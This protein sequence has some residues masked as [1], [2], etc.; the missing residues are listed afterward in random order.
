MESLGRC[1]ATV[2]HPQYRK[3]ATGL[4]RDPPLTAYGETQAEELREYFV[5]LPEEEQPTA[6]FASPYYRCLQTSRPLA[7]AL[8][9][10]IYV[11]HGLAEWYSPVEP[12]TGLHPRPGP[13]SGLQGFFSEVDPSWATVYYP[14]RKGETVEALHD[15]IDDFAVAFQQAM[16]KRLPKQQCRRILLV[17]H[18][19]TT[20]ALT[21]S[22]VGDRALPMKVGCCS[23]TE[24]HR[25]PDA[26][27][28]QLIGNYEPVM[29]VSGDHLKG[30]SSREWG[31]ED[32]EV[33]KGR[34]VEDPG[35]PG[36]E[37]DA[38]V[39]IGVQY[40]DLQIV[41]NL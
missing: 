10:P 29:L 41:S 20:I 22:F 1:I 40:D 16:E 26:A 30:G 33:E 25:K 23:L 9:I 14:S 37:Q 19:A 28:P 15:R 27:G 12:G 3:S 39:P 7:Q 24:L 2:A 17:T 18:A 6:I 21:R 5:S 34:V 4:P 38:D 32:I 35:V 8:G 36:S 11:E 31:F 13:T